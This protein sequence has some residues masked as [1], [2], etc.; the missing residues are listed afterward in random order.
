MKYYTA[1]KRQS[2]G[3]WDYTSNDRPIGYCSEYV[4]PDSYEEYIRKYMS[5]SEVERIK[6][7]KN[8]HHNH[9]H[10][11][12][13]EACQCYKEY[14]LDNF[15]SLNR[16]DENSQHRCKKCNEWTQGLAGVGWYSL[17]HLCEKH[18]TREVI[19]E[20]YSVGESWES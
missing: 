11:T 8:K 17:W 2:D 12:K 20:F 15:L 1:L 16:K 7:F 4:D 3:F 6:S 5:D 9:G 13:E 18:Q 19:S 10:I 14:M